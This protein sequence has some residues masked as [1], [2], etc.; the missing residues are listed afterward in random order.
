AS[1]F[2][3][4]RT[5][6]GLYAMGDPTLSGQTS[7]GLGSSLADTTRPASLYQGGDNPAETPEEQEKMT[8]EERAQRIAEERSALSNIVEWARLQIFQS[9]DLRDSL[10]PTD[11]ND[12]HDHFSDVDMSLRVT[13]VEYFS[14]TYGATVNPRDQRLT[15]ASVGVLVR[16]PRE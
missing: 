1:P 2:D 6:G 9:Y 10:Q 5:R 7:Q 15:S 3:D 14:L 16:D 13:P 4:E 8:P 12:K 11:P